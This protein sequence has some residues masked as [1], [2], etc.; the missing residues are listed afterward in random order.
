MERARPRE[1]RI[2]SLTTDDVSNTLEAY[3]LPLITATVPS[4]HNNNN[5]IVCS[6]HVCGCR[7]TIKAVVQC[8][9]V[10]HISRESYGIWI[11]H[12]LIKLND[13]MVTSHI[14]ACCNHEDHVDYSH[15]NAEDGDLVVLKA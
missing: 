12:A 4:A 3:R 2:M 8:D 15:H 13:C 14:W 10:V 7:I 9:A 6:L 5:M 11:Q 1:S